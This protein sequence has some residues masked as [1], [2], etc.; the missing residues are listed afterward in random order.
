MRTILAAAISCMIGAFG[1]GGAYALAGS[2]RAAWPCSERPTEK[3]CTT[4]PTTTPP[5]TSTVTVSTPGSTTPGETVTVTTPAP[6]QTVTLTTTIPGPGTTTTVVKVK[7]KPTCAHGDWDITAPRCKTKLIA[8]CKGKYRRE[9]RR[10]CLRYEASL[11]P[12]KKAGQSGNKP[13][14]EFKTEAGVTG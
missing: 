6:A 9:I 1:L 8:A 3:D 10:W 4:T 14:E 11:R 12:K 7:G 13:R 5:A 2:E